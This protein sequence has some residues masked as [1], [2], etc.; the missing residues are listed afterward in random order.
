[1][2]LPHQGQRISVSG[3]TSDSTY[4]NIVGSLEQQVTNRVKY[5]RVSGAASYLNWLQIVVS[6]WEQVIH[7]GQHSRVMEHQITFPW[8]TR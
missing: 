8:L 4:V 5:S 3:G 6:V 7:A 2:W 1:M